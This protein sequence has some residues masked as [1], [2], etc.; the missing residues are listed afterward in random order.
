MEY[1]VIMRMR[2]PKDPEAQKRWDDSRPAHLENTARVQVKGH[3]LIGGAIFDDDGNP[4]GSAAVATF[5]SREKFDECLLTD[6]Y[7][8]A[9]VWQDFEVIPSRVAPN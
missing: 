8:M 2:D 1:L 6:P 9:D 3:L 7:T 5:G 4:T